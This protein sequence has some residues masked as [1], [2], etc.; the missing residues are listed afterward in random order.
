MFKKSYLLSALIISLVIFI[1]VFYVI[2]NIKTKEGYNGS[3]MEKKLPDF[4]LKDHNEIDI[5]LSDFKGKF[6]LLNFGYTSCPDICPA[7]LANLR[8]VYDGIENN[9][10]IKVVF[11]SV[12]RDRDNFEKLKSYVTY[13]HKDFVGLSGTEDQMSKVK[14]AFNIFYFKEG[15]ESE[16]NYLITHPTSI[17]LVDRSNKLILR[18]PHSISSSEIVEDLNKL[19]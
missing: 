13:F 16:E 3:Y 17:Y 12:D 14:D 2:N 10:D 8:Q 5:A 1:G 15:D 19:L 11:I 6:I 4:I 7:T 9:Q 18:Y